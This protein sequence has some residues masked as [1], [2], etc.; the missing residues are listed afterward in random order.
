LPLGRAMTRVKKPPDLPR[1]E[2]HATPATPVRRPLG[3]SSRSSDHQSEPT[4]LSGALL[5]LLCVLAASE[6]LGRL[7]PAAAGLWACWACY[8]AYTAE[9]TVVPANGATASAAPTCTA[10]PTPSYKAETASAQSR[11]PAVEPGN[12]PNGSPSPTCVDLTC[13]GTPA[14]SESPPQTTKPCADPNG[15]PSPATGATASA[16][17]TCTASPTPSFKAETA[18]AHSRLPATA[19]GTGPH[20]P[21]NA[22]N[23]AAAS[24]APLCNGDA[25]CHVGPLN[26]SPTLET[27]GLAGDS[28]PGIVPDAAT[29]CKDGDA[30]G[31]VGPL[32]VSPT[33]ETSG[34][35]GDSS[36]GIVPDAATR[37]SH[38]QGFR[39][40]DR[41]V[42]RDLASGTRWFCTP[43]EQGLAGGVFSMMLIST[44]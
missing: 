20:R 19:P 6:F 28:S 44:C 23:R 32:N 31:H 41:F 16:A 43:A 15:P 22:D 9:G 24:A 3:S 7:V 37:W 11:L 38:R 40:G 42:G 39:T 14:R 18:S 10:S 8:S 29:R 12:V 25:E 13:N 5:T 1:H 21:S 34:L 36:P 4:V 2:P 26:V 33:L 35:A 27:S 30:E 17:P